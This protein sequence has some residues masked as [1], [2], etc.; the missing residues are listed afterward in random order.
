MKKVKYFI[1][2]VG[3]TLGLGLAAL[4]PTVGAFNPYPDACDGNS[5]STL[6]NNQTDS[7]SGFI[8]TVVNT[9][10]YVIGTVSVITII[11]GGIRYTTSHGDAKGVQVAKDTVLYSVIGLAV[12]ISAYAIV[13]FVVFK[14]FVK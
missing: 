10:L 9:L 6:C 2:I 1:A 5:D 3:L 11:I 8:Q 13:N 7:F 12:A 4:S 14:F